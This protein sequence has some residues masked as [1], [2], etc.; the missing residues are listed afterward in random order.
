MSYTPLNI[1]TGREKSRWL[2]ANC[3]ERI[4][5]GEPRGNQ[6]WPAQ[7]SLTP[8]QVK[9]LLIAAA[10][11]ADISEKAGEPESAVGFVDWMAVDA[12]RGEKWPSHVVS[13]GTKA[14]NINGAVA[15]LQHQGN[16]HRDPFPLPIQSNGIRHTKGRRHTG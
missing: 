6:V 1:R 13:E 12:L 11:Y 15:R 16:V 2:C 4:Y 10:E 8:D 7:L 14:H 5:L 9:L 3:N